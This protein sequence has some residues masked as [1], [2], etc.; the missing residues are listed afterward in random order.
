MPGPFPSLFQMFWKVLLALALAQIVAC[1]K[2][3]YVHYEESF[4][5]LHGKLDITTTENLL[6]ALD[7]F[8]IKLLNGTKKFNNHPNANALQNV[9]GNNIITT[10]RNLRKNLDSATYSI[11]TGKRGLDFLGATGFTS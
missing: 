10:S 3:G 1:T 7:N 4:Q 2:L 8:G 9:I 5:I 6:T 11:S